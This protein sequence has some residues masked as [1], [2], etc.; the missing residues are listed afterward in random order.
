MYTVLC[1]YGVIRY[2]MVIRCKIVFIQ[3]RT[4]HT[5]KYGTVYGIV[6]KAGN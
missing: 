5:V 2:G 1:Q 3:F 6:Q 4:I